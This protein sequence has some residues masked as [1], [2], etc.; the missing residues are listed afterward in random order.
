MHLRPH[1]VVAAVVLMLGV[2]SRFAQGGEALPNVPA[3]I[4]APAGHDVK[5]RFAGKGVQIYKCMPAAQAAG[6]F[7]WS[8]VAPEAT[9]SDGGGKTVGRH[10]AGPTWESDDGSKITGKLVAKAPAP[11]GVS[12][13]WLILSAT[14]VQG[15]NTFGNVAFVQRVQTSG[16]S[17]P[18]TGCSS[19]TVNKE[20][21][22]PYTADYYFLSAR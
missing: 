7:A 17:A 20:E 15:G 22:V 19:E 5:V 2:S 21:R 6:E 18:A 4:A 12:I 11:D 16:G 14:V 13:P 10:Y 8:F 1:W 9:L 3:A